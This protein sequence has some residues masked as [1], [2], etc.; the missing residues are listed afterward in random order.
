MELHFHVVSKPDVLECNR[1]MFNAG[2]SGSLNAHS[3]DYGFSSS[4][5]GVREAANNLVTA[6]QNNAAPPPPDPHVVKVLLHWLQQVSGTSN[7][8]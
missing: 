7:S 6:I 1:L 3:P 8:Q 5:V 4:A 2:N